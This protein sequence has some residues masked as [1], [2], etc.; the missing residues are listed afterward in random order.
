MTTLFLVD[1]RELFREGFRLLLCLAARLRR[2]RRVEPRPRRL[3]RGQRAPP[4]RHHRLERARRPRR[5][6]RHPRAVRRSSDAK[7]LML[8][9]RHDDDGVHQALAA[10]A[11]G[12]VLKQQSSTQ[13][14]EAVRAVAPATSTWRRRSRTG[15]RRITCACVAA[16]PPRPAPATS[17][18]GASATSSSCSCAVTPTAASRAC[19]ASA[20]RPSRPIAPT[21]CASSGCTRSSTSSASPR[22]ISCRSTRA[23]RR[24]K[25]SA[26]ALPSSVFPPTT[27]A[28]Q[29]KMDPVGA[30]SKLHGYGRCYAVRCGT[31]EVFVSLSSPPCVLT[32]S[33]CALAATTT[34][35]ARRSRT[36]A[37][38]ASAVP[39]SSAAAGS[40]WSA[41]SPTW[42]SAC[43]AATCRSTTAAAQRRPPTQPS[44]PDN[45]SLGGSCAGRDLGDATRP[46]SSPASSPTCSASGRTSCRARARSTSR[47]TSCSS[48][49]ATQSGCG[50]ASAG[51]RPVLLSARRQG[52]PR[53]RLLPRAVAALRRARRRLRAGLRGRARVRPPRPGPPR[54]RAADAHGRGAATAASATRCRCASSCRPT[55]SPASGATPPT[56]RAPCQPAEIAQALDAAAA[57]GDDRIQKEVQG[58]VSPETFTHGSAAGAAALVRRRHAV[59]Q[60]RQLRHVRRALTRVLPAREAG[61]AHTCPASLRQSSPAVRP[62]LDSAPCRSRLRSSRR[63]AGVRAPSLLVSSGF[64]SARSIS[65]AESAGTE[66]RRTLVQSG[67]IERV[68]TGGGLEGARRAVARH[69][70]ARPEEHAFADV[71][72][73]AACSGTIGAAR[74]GRRP[75]AL[76]ARRNRRR[77]AATTWPAVS[78]DPHAAGLAPGAQDLGD[79]PRLRD[80][81][82]RREGR[83]GVEDLGDRC[84]RTPRGRARRSRRAARAR[85]RDRSGCTRSHASTNGPMSQLHTVP[86]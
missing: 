76:D 49:D 75:G 50:T 28:R 66:E 16:R 34:R 38:P 40:A 51:D 86:W 64:R 1:D 70:R 71:R 69:Q 32:C 20:R 68:G 4:R 11:R 60:H 27:R 61:R 30:V 46:S 74:R 3:R 84:R 31:G 33:A 59:G 52:L 42:S 12:F 79:A 17:C 24:R 77:A 43:S 72:A 14:F 63:G 37:A 25:R 7:V 18:R 36:A 47:R 26:A 9:A 39:C 10:G 78:K 58:R 73:A 80:A 55:A 15:A 21:C 81:A 29:P 6:R 56:R 85:R 48:R 62:L 8:S 45:A 22:A 53:P 23:C 65:K 35:T 41:S 44:A 13:V 2:G 67:R 5:Q 82:A 57:V 83:L 19:S 54:H